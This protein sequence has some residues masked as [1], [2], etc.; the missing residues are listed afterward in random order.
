[1]NIRV[2]RTAFL[3]SAMACL[4]LNCS[5]VIED[6]EHVKELCVAVSQD[7]LLLDDGNT[8]KPTNTSGIAIKSGG[9][10]QVLY[11]LASGQKRDKTV[12][13]GDILDLFPISIVPFDSDTTNLVERMYDPVNLDQIWTGGGFLNAT[14]SSHMPTVGDSLHYQL[15]AVQGKTVCIDLAYLGKEKAA[16]S[17]TTFSCRI[18]EITKLLNVNTLIVKVLENQNGNASVKSYSFDLRK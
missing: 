7:E 16:V 13:S 15:E 3:C 2:I 4:L 6:N 9:R 5:Q 8:L 18:S 17:P 11:T 12:F 1:M 14:I 10:Y